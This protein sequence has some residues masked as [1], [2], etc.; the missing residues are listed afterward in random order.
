MQMIFRKNKTRRAK[1]DD[2]HLTLGRD[3]SLAHSP[4]CNGTRGGHVCS[5]E[6]SLLAFGNIYLWVRDNDNMDE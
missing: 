3:V 6:K 2:R 5:E 1:T 4:E